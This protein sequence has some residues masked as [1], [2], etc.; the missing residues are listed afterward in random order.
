MFIACDERPKFPKLLVEQGH[1]LKINLNQQ[2]SLGRTPMIIAC[3]NKSQRLVRA[4]LMKHIDL[5]LYTFEDRNSAIHWACLSS[6]HTIVQ[7]V[8]KYAL[9]SK[10]PLVTNNAQ[11]E[12]GVRILLSNPETSEWASD[13]VYYMVRSLYE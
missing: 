12:T 8:F 11:D 13:Y 2:D 5:N 4:L 3:Q 9:K 10:V 6:D 1:L 7:W